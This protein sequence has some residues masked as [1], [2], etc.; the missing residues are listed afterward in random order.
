MATELAHPALRRTGR[1]GRPAAGKAMTGSAVGLII[2]RMASLGLGFLFWLAAARVA[3]PAQVGF[4][5]ALVSA[6]M[7]RTQFAQ[8]GAGHAFLVLYPQALK[9]PKRLPGPVLSMAALG[10]IAVGP[11]VL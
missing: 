1:Q 10:T 3:E 9:E 2:G 6:M 7:L 11:T 5:A 4:T 8:L